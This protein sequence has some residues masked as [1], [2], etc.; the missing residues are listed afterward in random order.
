MLRRSAK[1]HEWKDEFMR[2]PGLL[3][4]V[5]LLLPPVPGF[6]DERQSTASANRWNRLD[7]AHIGPRSD[8]ALVFDPVAKR[9]LVL[10]GGIPWPIYAKQPHP[11]DDLALDQAA[12]QWE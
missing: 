9:F 6:G 3:L 5:I 8:P 7:K 4:S 11:Y 12:G 1:Q 2:T 10:G